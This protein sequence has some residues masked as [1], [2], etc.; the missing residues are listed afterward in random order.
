MS[1]ISLQQAMEIASRH[2]LSGDRAQ[3]E[4]I[5]R[6]I[7]AAD[8]LYADASHRLGIV[9]CQ[10]G[11]MEEGAACLRAA[12]DA[13][14]T[15]AAMLSDLGVVLHALGFIEEAEQACRRATALQPSIKEAHNNLGISLI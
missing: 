2:E 8:P 14:P 1:G 5:Y 7:L 9:L 6:Q 15:S 12:V 4:S 13:R 10:T 11:R 3:A